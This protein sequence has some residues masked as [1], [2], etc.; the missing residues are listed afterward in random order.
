MIL[1]MPGLSVPKHGAIVFGES[2]EVKLHT[3][4]DRKNVSE[5][6]EALALDARTPQILR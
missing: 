4:C 1:S 5:R 6:L 2:R 3:I